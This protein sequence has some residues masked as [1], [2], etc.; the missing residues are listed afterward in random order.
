MPYID[1]SGKKIM[2]FGGDSGIGK[3]TAVSL[4]RLGAKLVLVGRNKDR[5][6]QAKAELNPSADHA[7]IPYDVKNTDGCKELFDRAVADGQK[8]SGLV[9]CAGIAKAVP[10]RVM[11]ASEYQNIFSVNFFGFVNAVSVFAKRKYNAGGSIVGISA[12]NAH[13]PQKCMTL[14]AASKAAVEAA[15]TTMALE[16][17]E[18]NIRINAVVPGA[19]ATPMSYRIDKDTLDMIV[20]RQL[21]G[22][23]SPEQIADSIIFLLSE[24]S[25]AITGRSLYV[26]GGMLGQ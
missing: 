14:Y 9:Y 15:V 23:Q 12:A 24:R 3:Q 2:V 20:S 18:Q 10:L 4:D 8:L 19:V 1:F 22:I 17:A 21:L 6:T 25:N 26:D 16:L 7:V 11:S 13:Y 5:L